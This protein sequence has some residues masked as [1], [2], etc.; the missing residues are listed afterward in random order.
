MFSKPAR[1][2]GPNNRSI[3]GK[4]ITGKSPTSQHFE[5]ALERDHFSLL[6]YDP[7]IVK[8]TAQPV[9]IFYSDQTYSRRYTPDVAVYY[10]PEL[11]RK[12]LLIEVKYQAELIKK[13]DALEPKFNAARKYARQN[14]YEFRVIT[15]NEIRTDRLYNVKFL[16]RYKGQKTD[17]GLLQVINSRY[18]QQGVLTPLQLTND[19]SFELN[20]QLLYTLWQLVAD[21]VLT[22]DMDEK[23]TMN[24][25]IWKQQ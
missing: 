14:G 11:E 21:R 13:K 16:N 4:H 25:K 8:F 17:A 15:E 18:A 5:S 22:F 19:L 24:T 1:K 3:T 9:T 12:P 6:E 2:I 10:R 23:I 20:D 7:D